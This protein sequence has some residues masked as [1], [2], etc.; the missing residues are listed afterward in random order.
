MV[1]GFLGDGCFGEGYE[2]ECDSWRMRVRI[3]GR[4]TFCQDFDLCRGLLERYSWL[5]TPEDR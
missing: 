1:A 5:Q 2:R 3:N 4:K